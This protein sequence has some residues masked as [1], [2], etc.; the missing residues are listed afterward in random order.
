MGWESES[1]SGSGWE[2]ER[3]REWD[4]DHDI[5]AALEHPDRV[6]CIKLVRY[7]GYRMGHARRSNAGA[8]PGADRSAALVVR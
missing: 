8:I 5:I 1:G 4:W 2:R 7:P 6:R 3:E